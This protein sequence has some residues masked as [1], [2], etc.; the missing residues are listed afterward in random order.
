MFSIEFYLKSSHR[1]KP[2]DLSD[3]ENL[4]ENIHH[5]EFSAFKINHRMLLNRVNINFYGFSPADD[6]FKI[7]TCNMCGMNLKQQALQSHIIRRHQQNLETFDV[8]SKLQLSSSSSSDDEQKF[9]ISSAQIEEDFK[10]KNSILSQ[11]LLFQETKRRKLSDDTEM[12]NFEHFFLLNCS[13]EMQ[14]KKD[15]NEAGKIKMK[16]K[17]FSGKWAV[18]GR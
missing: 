13:P 11:N 3:L 18:V 5:V 4:E 10:L 15:E 8:S 17:K 1:K 12:P 6:E 16:L 9:E 7:V 2:S 14:E